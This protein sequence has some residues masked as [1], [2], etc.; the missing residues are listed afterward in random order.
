METVKLNNGI[1]MPM[2]GLGTFQV[3]D[4]ETCERNVLEALETGYRLIDTAQAYGNEEYIGRALAHSNVPRE[5]LFLTTKVWFKDYGNAYASVEASLRR[6]RTDY[7]DLVLL[8]WPFGDTY[9]AWRDL[10]RLYKEG[11]VRAIGVSNYTAD[12]LIDLVNYNEIVPAVNQI[13]TNLVSQQVETR[14]WMDKLGIRHQSYA[15]FGQGHI[16]S[17][18]EDETLQ[19]IAERYRK[20]PRQVVLRFLIQSGVIVIPKTV[21]RERLVENFD[22]FDFHLLDNEMEILRSYDKA[23]PLIGNPLNPALV[24]SSKN[25]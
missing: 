7:L 2:L 8:H 13:E 20:T 17:I 4:P 24:E 6:L 5:E 25:W 9:A 15:P 21:H 14:R 19:H 12:R 16:D 23:S 1:T 3:T 22:V 18:Y 10:E 11:K